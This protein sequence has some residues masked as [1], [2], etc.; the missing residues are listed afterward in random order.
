MRL[1]RGGVL[2]K[3]SN[4]CGGGGRNMGVGGGEVNEIVFFFCFSFC[5]FSFLFWENNKSLR[6]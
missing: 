5:F 3:A 4:A 6:L 2:L 1:Y